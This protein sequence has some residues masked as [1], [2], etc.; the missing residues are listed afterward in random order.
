MIFVKRLGSTIG[1]ELK[2]SVLAE[3]FGSCGEIW[4]LLV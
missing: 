1:S 4:N 2:P 3:E